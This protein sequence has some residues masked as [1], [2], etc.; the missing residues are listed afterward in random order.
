M[1]DER[2]MKSLEKVD[3]QCKRFCKLGE[4]SG[5]GVSGTSETRSVATDR[6]GQGTLLGKL[7]TVGRRKARISGKEG[8]RTTN[9]YC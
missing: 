7:E 9:G 2:G 5:G 6:P 1:W 8:E 3:F 4:Y